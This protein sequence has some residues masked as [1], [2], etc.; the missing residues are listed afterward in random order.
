MRIVFMG[1]PD[2][3]VPCLQALLDGGHEVV[4][5]FTQPDKPVGRKQLLTPPP[6]KA[7][8]LE[9]GIPVHQPVKMRDGTVAA[10]LRTLAP[11]VLV[12]VAYGRILPKEVLE[13][14]KFG[15]INVHGSLLPK[16]RGAAPIQ[17]SV[18][19][20]DREAGVTTMFMAEGMDTGDMLLK[21][22]VEI[23]PEET[24]GELFARLS[25]LGAQ[26]L[27]ETLALL[28]AGALVPEPQREEEAS[29]APML[30]KEMA[31]LDFTRTAWEVHNHIR[32]LNPWPI[33]TTLLDG[34]TLKIHRAR[35]AEGFAGA[36][37]T[38]LDER[39]FIVGCG[40]GA[41]EFLEVQ[42]E[43]GKRLSA[44]EFL[45]GQRLNVGKTLTGNS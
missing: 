24:A 9:R 20:G 43:G 33:A 44:G 14:P 45:R 22:A 17:W 12:V 21:K 40:S 1:T 15:C 25:P 27:L 34:K 31:K 4:G 28:E 19:N 3:A 5:V 41:V 6:V 7:L 23:G 36:P 37:G 42:G 32:G 38:L 39:R 11:E 13:V 18:L 35:V 10:L 30:D 2:F 29:P 8:A 16:Y 26:C